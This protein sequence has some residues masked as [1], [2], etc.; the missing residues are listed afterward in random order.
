MVT[1]EAPRHLK[2]GDDQG[3]VGAGAI[4]H[5]FWSSECFLLPVSNSNRIGSERCLFLWEILLLV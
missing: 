3:L 2:G 5:I 1:P 4:D